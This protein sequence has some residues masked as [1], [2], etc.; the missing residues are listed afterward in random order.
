MTIRRPLV[1]VIIPTFNSERFLE[2][3]LESVRAQTYRKIEIIVV[4]K[5]STDRTVAVA[6]K[7]GAKVYVL[8]ADERC[9]QMNY[10]VQKAEGE[11]VYIVGSDFVLEA[12]IVEEA[13]FKCEA[14]RL[15]AVCVHNTSDPSIS[16]WSQVRNLERDCYAGDKLN[17]AARFLR[18][19][20]FRKVGGFNERLVAAEDYDLHNRLLRCGFR[21]GEIRSKEVH[22]GEPKSLE[23]I[24]KKHYYYGKTVKRFLDVNPERGIR[25]ISPARIAFIRN[26]RHFAE[27]PLVACGFVL[28]QIVKY[29]A[30]GLGFLSSL[31]DDSPAVIS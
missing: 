22:I 3:C 7:A 17:V 6:K 20:V 2:K 14:E 25:Q 9:M 28:Y 5:N 21:I 29:S 26:G 31:I 15:D 11:F 24:A 19:E 18:T 23:E 16:F 10:G 12:S 13:V 27:R 1:S 8:G 30:A 4:D